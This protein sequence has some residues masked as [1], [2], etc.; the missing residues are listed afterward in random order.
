VIAY[1]DTSAI[2]PLVVDEPTTAASNRLWTESTRVVGSRLIYPEARAALARAE[3]RRRLTEN[4][5]HA[6]V[7]E[8]NSLV[9]E[10]DVIE[11]SP[12][13]ARSAGLAVCILR[14]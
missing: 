13:I 9:D 7:A 10:V 3:R 2:V 12:E 4:Q 1:F 8:L 5:L 14:D 11:L 6:V